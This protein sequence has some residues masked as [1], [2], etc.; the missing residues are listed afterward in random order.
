MFTKMRKSKKGF[1][2]IELIVVI[3][4]LGIL[5]LIAVPR[6]GGFR[7]SAN[8]AKDEA[9]AKIIADAVSMYNATVDPDIES[10]ALSTYSTNVKLNE[11]VDTGILFESKKYGK[12]VSPIISL[13][14]GSIH[15]S[16]TSSGAAITVYPKN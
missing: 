2:L 12:D 8:E 7:D 6:L 1:T 13:V 4:I 16:G 15:V 14:D 11:L 10:G 9:N 3:A 5:A